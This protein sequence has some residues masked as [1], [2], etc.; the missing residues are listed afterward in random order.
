MSDKLQE[1]TLDRFVDHFG[2]VHEKM[3]DS[4]F[5]WMLGAGTSVS[6]N[7]PL[8]K[9]LVDDWLKSLC[10][11]EC[12]DRRKLEIEEWATPGNLTKPYVSF[13]G[14]SWHNR[15]SF[16]SQVYERRFHD[17]PENGDAYLE[18]IMS[19][20]EPSPGYSILASALAIQ[21]PRH[22]A[23]VTTNFDNLVADALSSYT[24]T[25]TLVFGHESLTGY[26]KA[27]LR[28]PLVCKIHRDLLFGPQDK[29]R[30]LKRLHDSWGTALRALFGNY[31][32]IFIGYGG[33]DDTLMDLLESLVPGEVKGQMIWCYHES[34]N[35]RDRKDVIAERIRRV[36]AEH[37]GIPVSVPD[38]DL[39]MILLGERMG[40]GLLDA[41]IEQRSRNRVQHYRERVEQ[42]D[43]LK[44]PSVL[45]AFAAMTRRSDGWL[46]W[47]RKAKLEEDPERTELVYREGIKEFHD[48]AELHNNLAILLKDNIGN[49]DA[50]ERMFKRAIELDPQDAEYVGNYA[51]FL[52]DRGRLEE[53]A[54]AL[55]RAESLNEGTVNEDAAS[56]EFLRGILA[57]VNGED[58]TPAINAVGR[59]FNAGFARSGWT[60]NDVLSFA[61][62]KTTAE[63]Y[64]LYH[65]LAS[66]IL[67]KTKVPD[68]DALLTTRKRSALP[69]MSRKPATA[70]RK[71]KT[72]PKE[73]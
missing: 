71:K 34:D 48:S 14:F 7:I 8:A 29:S 60:Y 51:E 37:E 6:S 72:P 66:G 41:Q 28:R 12:K 73:G 2:F 57:C 38:F 56:F 67:D 53:A 26:V 59:L 16:Y 9:A 52:V 10:R 25:F 30:E 22:N 64:A 40:I 39:Q 19:Q 21:P 11:W 42:L 69:P 23:V 4:K 55:D 27:A 35:L 31:T 36:V 68:V 32:P 45:R 17:A 5:L 33:N 62:D 63:D 50:S 1:W 13:R 15:A 54:E 61:Q 46:T 65:A 49:Y 47:L 20:A 18:D 58:D 44:S 3:P 24:D 70:K 43:I